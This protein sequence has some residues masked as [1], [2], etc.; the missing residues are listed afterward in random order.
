MLAEKLDKHFPSFKIL[1]YD[2]IRN[3]FTSTEI[4]GLSLSHGKYENIQTGKFQNVH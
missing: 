4:S 2:L 3:S 1:E